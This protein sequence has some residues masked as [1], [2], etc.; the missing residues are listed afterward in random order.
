MAILASSVSLYSWQK[1]AN[2]K[3]MVTRMFQNLGKGHSAKITKMSH[4]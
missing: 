1:G 2:E 4:P 3:K